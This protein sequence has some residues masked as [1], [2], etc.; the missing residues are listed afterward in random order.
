MTNDRTYAGARWS[1]EHRAGHTES[2]FLK[3]NEPSG[4][5][6]IWLK[7]TLFQSARAG[8]GEPGSARQGSAIAETWAVAFT[9]GGP[10]VAVKSS[11]PATSA[12]ISATELDV[13]M[14]A[15]RL[16]PR[17]ARGT[18]DSG[19]RVIAVDLSID[20]RGGPFAA[21]SD[22]LMNGRFP[23]QKVASPLADARISGIARVDGVVWTLEG[24]PGMVGH[25]WGPRHTPLYAWVH[26]NAWN[27]DVDLVVE[28]MSGRSRVGPLLAPLGTIATVRVGAADLRMNTLASIA[29]NRA[30]V[31]PHRYTLRAYG[32]GASLEGEVIG[33]PS[34][35]VGLYYPN[36]DGPPTHCLNTK[37]ARA[38]F[39][40][41]TAAGVTRATSDACALEVGTLDPTHGV[42]MAL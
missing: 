22:G 23:T 31:S 37:L 7:W 8:R 35:T 30:T 20:A 12:R 39:E 5:R 42:R 34:H 18:T 10:Q 16:T 3:A 13:R 9:R 26:C 19:G 14:D 21:Y 6:A 15:S 4:Q 32:D 28:C 27:E 2:W 11:A 36:P 33:D 25:N 1:G 41:R 38:T 29:R 17:I 40:L 24:W